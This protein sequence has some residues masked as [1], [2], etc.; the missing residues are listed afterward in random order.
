[1]E[2]E[3]S[4][5]LSDTAFSPNKDICMGNAF[6]EL[7]DELEQEQEVDKGLNNAGDN[8]ADARCKDDDYRQD[9]GKGSSIINNNTMSSNEATSSNNNN[10]E[11]QVNENKNSARV[12]QQ[13]IEELSSTNKH[14]DRQ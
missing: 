14:K 13:H 11:S 8:D 3:S 9:K 6:E 7:S 2:K 1:M 4:K 10:S 12:D 5:F